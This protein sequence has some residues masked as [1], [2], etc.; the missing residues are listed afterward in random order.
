MGVLIRMLIYVAA[1]FLAGFG[2]AEFDSSMGTLTIN[3][4]Q[5]TVAVVGLAGVVG[6]F[7]VGRWGARRKGW[8]T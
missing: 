3:L 4:E 2:W 1:S 5:L 7:V 8:R 6:T